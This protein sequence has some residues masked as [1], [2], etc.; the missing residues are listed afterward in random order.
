MLGKARCFTFTSIKNEKYIQTGFV[1]IALRIAITS[2]NISFYS[3]GVK[4][5]AFCIIDM[6]IFKFLLM[7]RGDA[8][9]G[10][11]AKCDRQCQGSAERGT[12]IAK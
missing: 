11:P 8:R 1:A 9:K 7:W 3:T 2:E 12:G 6:Q 10:A 4:S 5:T